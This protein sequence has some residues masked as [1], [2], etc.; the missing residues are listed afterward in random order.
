MSNTINILNKKALALGATELGVS[1]VKNKKYYVIYNG[2]KI[3]FGSRT[4]KSFLDHR[5]EAKRTAWRARHSKIL[6]NGKP[7]YKNKESPS[8]WSWSI[9][10]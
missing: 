4:G 5:D 2:K 3:N 6:K 1:D 8:F 10:W 9:L 7:A